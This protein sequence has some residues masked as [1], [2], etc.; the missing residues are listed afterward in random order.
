MNQR[1]YHAKKNRSP[2]QKKP[3]P[4][5][6]KKQVSKVFKVAFYDT[7]NAAKA[8]KEE[9]QN[10]CASADQIN[11][12]IKAEGNMD[13]PDLLGIDEKVKIYAGEAWTNIHERRQEEGWYD[14]PQLIDW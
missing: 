6:A 10:L 12:V 2:R 5:Q 4:K 3:Y 11:V 13:D 1:S 9:I 8:Q 7:F 14:Q